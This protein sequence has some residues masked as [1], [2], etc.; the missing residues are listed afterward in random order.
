ML[1]TFTS[2]YISSHF[3]MQCI[4]SYNLTF[5]TDDA[6]NWRGTDSFSLLITL[7]NK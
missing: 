2:V 4:V 3:N 6:I 5:G 1:A 7:S